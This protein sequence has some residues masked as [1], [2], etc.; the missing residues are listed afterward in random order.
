MELEQRDGFLQQVHW[1][2]MPPQITEE[3]KLGR[4][5]LQSPSLEQGIK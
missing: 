4:D 2:H 3:M 5:N 1:R